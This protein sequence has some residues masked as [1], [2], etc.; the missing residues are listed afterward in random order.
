M[1]GIIMDM[2]LIN[3]DISLFNE[4]FPNV[5][6]W[7]KIKWTTFQECPLEW[8]LQH[9]G[10]YSYEDRPIFYSIGTNTIVLDGDYLDIEWFRLHEMGHAIHHLLFDFKQFNFP[11]K[12]KITIPLYW[13]IPNYKRNHYE[14]FADIVADTMMRFKNPNCAM[15]DYNKRMIRLIQGR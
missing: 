10:K 12:Y 15:F 5:I 11:T 14:I 8:L 3:Q 9:E 13:D 6:D 2:T 1:G 7:N 4:K